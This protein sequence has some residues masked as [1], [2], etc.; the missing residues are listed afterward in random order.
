MKRNTASKISP[1]LDS[2]SF[3]MAHGFSEEEAIQVASIYAELDE[4]AKELVRGYFEDIFGEILPI[5]HIEIDGEVVPVVE[6]GTGEDTL[7]ISALGYEG[8]EVLMSEIEGEGEAVTLIKID[9]EGSA[10]EREGL[11]APVAMDE[12][13]SLV[14]EPNKTV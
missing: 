11:D 7:F 6:V 9:G 10:F 13:R 1:S 12:G 2:I 4:S 14:I 5:R 3:Y 8:S